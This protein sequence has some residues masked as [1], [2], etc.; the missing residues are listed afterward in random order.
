[1][2]ITTQALEYSELTDQYHD[3]APRNNYDVR[4]RQTVEAD[5]GSNPHRP[6]FNDQAT[7]MHS[8]GRGNT[9]ASAENSEEFPPYETPN[10]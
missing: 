9:F 7:S 3:Q 8:R 5:Q 1:M 4:Q 10:P 2:R 6:T